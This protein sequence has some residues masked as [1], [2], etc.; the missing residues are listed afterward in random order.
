M[1]AKAPESREPALDRARFLADAA[2]DMPTTDEL[3]H[4]DLI[5]EAGVYATLAVAEEIRALRER[6]DS[7]LTHQVVTH[8]GD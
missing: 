8:R 6:L 5:V 3:E 4:D 7:D 1:A 2:H